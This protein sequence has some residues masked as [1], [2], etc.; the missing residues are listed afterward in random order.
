MLLI[1]PGVILAL[2]WAVVAQT[3]SLGAR[4]WKEAL[5]RSKLLTRK[6]YRHVFA[7]LLLVFV[8]TLLPSA[9][10]FPIFGLK[11]TT[12]SFLIEAVISIPVSSFNALAIAFLYFDLAARDKADP[13]EPEPNVTAPA[14][15]AGRP[16]T[17]DVYTDEGRPPG[18]YV[19]PRPSHALL[20]HGRHQGWSK[21]TTK[22]PEEAQAEWRDLRWRR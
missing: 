5:A 18:W 22:T 15:M 7:V 14:R 17:P 1:V 19:D 13:A 6:R 9:V 12:A 3:A 4:S 2:R 11:T 20:A 21:E 8:I 10:L 16:L